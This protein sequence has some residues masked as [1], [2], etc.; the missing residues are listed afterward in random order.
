MATSQRSLRSSER[1]EP[2][3][4]RERVADRLGDAI[5]SAE[6]RFGQVWMSVERDRLVDAVRVLKTDPD[7]LCGYLT[8]L[9]AID[10][11]DEGLDVVICLFS[12]PYSA[13]ALLRCRISSDDPRVP[14]ITGVLP[15]ANWHERVAAEMFGIDFEGHPDLTNLYLPDDFEG[16]PL[17]K[18][19]KLASR[20]YK[21]WPGAKDPSEA[22]AGGR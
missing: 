21:P 9:S 12:F 2:E 19:F 5:S 22:E 17:R 14:T 7:L 18:S 4:F 10:W 3:A 15:G 11:E 16:H 6:V 8:Y 20:T 1:V 13:T